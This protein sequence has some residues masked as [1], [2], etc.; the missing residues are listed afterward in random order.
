MTTNPPSNKT[1]RYIIMMTTLITI[2]MTWIACATYYTHRNDVALLEISQQLQDEHQ[3]SL[4]TLNKI[5]EIVR[6]ET[7]SDNNILPDIINRI[8]IITQINAAD[9][10]ATPDLKPIR[11]LAEHANAQ[12]TN[13][14]AT[15]ID[16][17]GGLHQLQILDEDNQIYRLTN[18]DSHA[19]LLLATSNYFSE[20]T[21]EDTKKAVG[22]CSYLGHRNLILHRTVSQN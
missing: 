17:A 6:E 15:S 16:T 20:I 14:K 12:Y 2:M 18:T 4:D 11:A 22:S 9:P 1:Y 19:C 7:I 13:G 5:K 21:Y 3:R 10:R 8:A